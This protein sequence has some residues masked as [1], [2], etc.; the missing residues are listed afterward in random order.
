MLINV[1]AK[2][3]DAFYHQQSTPT[4]QVTSLP[5]GTGPSP[6]PA[7]GSMKG[8]PLNFVIQ[9]NSTTHGT[10]TSVASLTAVGTGV[11]LTKGQNL[12]F[13]NM[14]ISQLQP[15]SQVVVQQPPSPLNQSI[16]QRGT[17]LFHLLCQC[18]CS[19][20]HCLIFVM[21]PDWICNM[22]F[23]SCVAF[24]IAKYYTFIMS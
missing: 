1:Y 17:V 4:V 2:N 6:P 19:S 20:Y 18:P 16:H 12:I 21:P 24:S 8:Y 13:N 22:P 3:N 9:G 7:G 14:G 23:P 11:S 5:N 15:Q 10:S